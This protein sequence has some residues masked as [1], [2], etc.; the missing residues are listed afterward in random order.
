MSDAPTTQAEARLEPFGSPRNLENLFLVIAAGVPWTAFLVYLATRGTEPGDAVGRFAADHPVALVNV[1]Y[2]A[3]ACVLFWLL[4]VA[5]KS[6]W[7]IDPYWTILP[8]FIA[9]TFAL[10]PGAVCD[11]ARAGVSLAGLVVWSARLTHNYFRREEWRFGWRE[12]WRF[13]EYRRRFPSH[14]WWMSFFVTYFSQQLM[15]VGL[16]LPFYAIFSSDRPFGVVDAIAAVGCFTGIATAHSADTEL[17]RFMLENERRR[18]AGEPPIPILETGLWRF[19]RHPNYFGEQLFWWS[20]ALFGV[21]LGHV[22]TAAGAALNSLVLAQ[23][24]VMTERRMAERPERAALFAAYRART[25]V[26]FPWPPKAS[27]R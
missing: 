4:G 22:W 20:L 23:V 24:T 25:S 9:A 26:W 14:W 17:R 12:D 19:S 7:L 10:V 15:L 11:P 13:G 21:G 27:G 6:T 2:F 18:D 5:Q 3:I 16:G 8:L 1:L